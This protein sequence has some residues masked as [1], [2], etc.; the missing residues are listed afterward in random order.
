MNPGQHS[1]SGGRAHPAWLR[2]LLP[3]LLLGV[4]A[5][6]A[7]VTWDQREGLQVSAFDSDFASAFSGGSPTW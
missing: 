2:A 3:V 7:W 6:C 5:L 1:P 4:V